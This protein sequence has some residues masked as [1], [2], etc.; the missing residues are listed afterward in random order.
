MAQVQPPLAA[1]L[2][3]DTAMERAALIGT[4][5]FGFD[6]VTRVLGLTVGTD[7]TA[8]ERALAD[9]IQRLVDQP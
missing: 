9:S 3:G 6:M 7:L 2:H 5:I 1:R 4:L 8:L